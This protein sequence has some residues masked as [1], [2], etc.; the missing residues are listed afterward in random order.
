MLMNT[1]HFIQKIYS[2]IALHE[3]LPENATIIVGLSGGPDSLFLLHLLAQLM[4][5]K[6]LSLIAAHLDHQWRTDSGAD[7][8]FCASFAQRLNIPFISSTMSELA[9]P[10]HGSKEEQGRAARRAFFAQI[11]AQH[12]HSLIALAHHLQDQQE[13][14][15]IRLIRGTTLSGLAVMRPKQG[16]YIRPLLETNKEDIIAY[17]QQHDLEYLTDPT[18]RSPDFLRN[19]IRQEVLPHLQNVD[20]RFN[21]NFLTTLQHLQRTEQFLEQL[22]QTTLTQLSTLHE[23]KLIIDLDALGVLPSELYQR[24]I[25]AWLWHEKVP[26]TPTQKFIHEVIRFLQSPESKIHHIHHA[27]YITKKKKQAWVV[28]QELF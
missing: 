21:N 1:S 22:T 4:H 24:V 10:F 14:F 6:N 13:T 7:V 12:P 26:F 25:C 9:G 15:F 27:W 19:R 28:K 5:K 2:F 16:T 17:L 20:E 3:L 8:A 18:N 11:Q 23:G